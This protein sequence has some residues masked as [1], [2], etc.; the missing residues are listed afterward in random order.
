MN[1]HKK[2]AIIAIEPSI[3]L[4]DFTPNTALLY[5]DNETFAL[6]VA[7]TGD[8]LPSL[9]M[10][11]TNAYQQNFNQWLNNSTAKKNAS[12]SVSPIVQQP[13]TEP[14]ECQKPN[15]YRNTIIELHNT[16]LDLAQ[17]NAATHNQNFWLLSQLDQTLLKGNLQI[18]LTTTESI[19]IEKMLYHEERVVSKDELIRSIGRE[20]DLYRGLEMCLSRLQSKFKEL[21]DGERLFR[22]VRNRGYCLTQKIKNST[23]I[24]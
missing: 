22:A 12:T 1:P 2:H 11:G 6:N 20:P 9:G 14:L 3:A 10:F 24:V 21:N 18:S 13:K 4:H 23:E 16:T 7:S 8:P 17:E 5:Y 19:L 15:V